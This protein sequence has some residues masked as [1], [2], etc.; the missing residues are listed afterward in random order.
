MSEE[1]RSEDFAGR[2]GG[3]EFALVMAADADGARAIC[4]RVRT[5]LMAETVADE[6]GKTVR[7]TVSAGFAIMDKERASLD[8][9]LSAA[10]AALY[11]AKEAGRNRV[12]MF[13]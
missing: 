2:I 4:E 13:K 12:E 5:R 6:T 7:F 11:R 3:E 8:E 10:D 1:I 9:L